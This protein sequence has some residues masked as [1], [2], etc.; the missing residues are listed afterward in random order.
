MR[1]YFWL[2]V[3]GYSLFSSCN[4]PNVPIDSIAEVPCADALI[5]YAQQYPQAE[6]ADL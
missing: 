4:A 3:I 6:P 1:R 5:A 2:L